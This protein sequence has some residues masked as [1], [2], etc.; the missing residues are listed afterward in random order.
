M[1]TR[2]ASPTRRPPPAANTRLT[3]TAWPRTSPSD[4]RTTRASSVAADLVP[5]RPAATHGLWSLRPPSSGWTSVG[6][7]PVTARTPSSRATAAAVPA[8]SGVP[9]VPTRTCGAWTR[10][11]VTASVLRWLLV[12]DA[13]DAVEHRDEHDRRRQ[14]CGAPA[15]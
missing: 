4:P 7:T 1:R 15:V 14:R 12:D 6:R 5:L 9:A 2:T 3:A 13:L 8:R 11:A 10:A